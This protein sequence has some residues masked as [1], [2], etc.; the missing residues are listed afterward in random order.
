MKALYFTTSWDDGHPHDLRVAELLTK[1][2]F[3]GTFYVPWRNSEGRPVM[4]TNEL[5][6]LGG[7]FE[8]GAHTLD[9]VRLGAV[10]NSR[11]RGQILDGKRRLEDVLGRTL[12]GFCYPGGEHNARIRRL[13]REACF[14]YARTTNN[15][16][17]RA[18]ADS[19]RVPTT[20]QLYRHTPIT[21][22][23][24]FARRGEWG[25]RARI[26]C[27]ALRAPTLEVLLRRLF[28]VIEARG[29]IFHLWG[30]SW[31]LDEHG[32]WPVLERFLARTSTRVPPERRV[33]NAALYANSSM[34]RASADTSACSN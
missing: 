12:T 24:N 19:F 11:A 18:G 25:A 1:Y 27:E 32:L 21:Y 31:E 15:F 5:R 4:S 6:M 3:Q 34:Q 29:G 2:G 8:I 17:A 23:K 13:V 7:S 20:L 26:A 22:A 28:D 16:H 33:H 30:H 10:G 14:D 9:H